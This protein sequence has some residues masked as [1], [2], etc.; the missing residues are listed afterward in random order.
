MPGVK[1]VTISVPDGLLEEIDDLARQRGT[2]RSGLLQEAASEYVAT[3]KADETKAVREARWRDV[4]KRLERIRRAPDLCP[5]ETTL[6]TI[7]RLREERERRI[8]GEDDTDD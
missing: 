5:G 6:E 3:T 4:E 2:T 1:K 8:L 7:H